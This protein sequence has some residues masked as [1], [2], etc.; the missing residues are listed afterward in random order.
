METTESRTQ[1]VESHENELRKKL[2]FLAKLEKTIKTIK[3]QLVGYVNHE[4]SA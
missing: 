2:M 4:Q 3:E 1:K